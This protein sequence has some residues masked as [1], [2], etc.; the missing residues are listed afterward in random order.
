MQKFC[1]LGCKV[2]LHATE[3]YFH[4]P[5]FIVIPFVNDDDEDDDY[6]D[7]DGQKIRYAF[8]LARWQNWKPWKYP[9]SYG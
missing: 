5:F 1:N 9:D 6:D 8:I 3:S 7:V 4:L 2:R